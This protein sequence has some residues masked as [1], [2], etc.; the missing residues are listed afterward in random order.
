[1]SKLDILNQFTPDELTQHLK[2][3]GYDDVLLIRDNRIM[4]CKTY[5]GTWML[6]NTSFNEFKIPITNV[7]GYGGEPGY[8]IYGKKPPDELILTFKRIQK[9]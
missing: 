6:E 9:L 2:R 4:T 5:E 7:G 3:Q 8:K 1:M